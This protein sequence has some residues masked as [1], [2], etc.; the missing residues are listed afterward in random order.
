[1]TLLLLAALLQPADAADWPL[2]GRDATRNMVS[3]EKGPTK[4]EPGRFVQGTEQVDP[5]TTKGV[6]R[7][8]K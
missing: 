6:P 7:R 1:M 3:D 8:S 2:W 5:A 4:F